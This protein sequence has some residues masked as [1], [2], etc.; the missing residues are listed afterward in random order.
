MIVQIDSNFQEPLQQ[1]PKSNKRFKSRM[2][3]SERT[4]RRI[5]KVLKGQTESF[6][7]INPNAAGIDVGSEQMFVSVPADRDSEPVRVF[8]SYT[9]DLYCLADWL[10]SCTITSVV[11]ESTGFPYSKSSNPEGLKSV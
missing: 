6:D 1:V 11:M 4:R 9:E 2:T 5:L 8:S 10:I 7:L 3:K